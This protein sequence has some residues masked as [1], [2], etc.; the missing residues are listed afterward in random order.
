MTK[1]ELPKRKS[2]RL[3]EYDYS[4]N[5]CYFVTVCVKGKRQLLGHYKS[6][7]DIVGA[8]LRARPREAVYLTRLGRETE[9]SILF[10]EKIYENIRIEN[11]IIMPNHIHLLISINNYNENT[12]SFNAGGRGNPPLHKIV[13]SIKSY[14]TKIYR[15]TT[16]EVDLL[17]QRGFYDRIIRNQSEFEK[18][19]EYIENNGMKEY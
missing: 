18:A 3:K 4:L 8:G 9:K 11:Y 13:G 17:W 1:N 2:T 19:W 10:V 15:E 5:G 7:T 6:K 14:T 12:D 16:N